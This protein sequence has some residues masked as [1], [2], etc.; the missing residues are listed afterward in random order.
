MK[1]FVLTDRRTGEVVFDG[2]EASRNTP[3]WVC[4]HNHR[5]PSWCLV[6]SG[7]RICICQRIQSDKKIGEAGWWHSE[8]TSDPRPLV[9]RRTAAAE[10]TIDW[11][12]VWA[13]MIERSTADSRLELANRLGLP[14]SFAETLDIGSTGDSWSFAMRDPR[15]RICGIKLRYR[16]GRKICVRG[17]HLGLVWAKR[18]DQTSTTL[19]VT[20][21]ESD[22]MVAGGWGYNAV[23]KPSSNSCKINIASLSAGKDVV[24]VADRDPVGKRGATETKLAIG[25]AARSCIV[26]LPPTKDLREWHKAGA[27]NQEFLWLIKAIRGF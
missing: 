21:G 18:L 23:A 24:I 20:E 16:D 25:G 12:S 3:C 15:G 10:T 11:D 9:F 7:R 22:C 1:S 26:L 19:V 27:T 17:S 14:R 4:E 8:T 2:I 5:T 6:D 13:K